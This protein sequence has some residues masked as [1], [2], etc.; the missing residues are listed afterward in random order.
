MSFE[1]KV[2]LITGAASG[3]GAETA[4]LLASLGGYLA[5]VD[6]NS[7]RLNHVAEE[8]I[9][10][11]HHIPFTIVADLTQDADHIIYE[12]IEKFGK[13]NVLINNVGVISAT[14][15]VDLDMG[16]YDLVM[17]TNVRSAVVLTKLAAPYLE[18]SKGNIVNVSSITGTRARPSRLAY[19]MSKAALNQFTKCIA[20][21]LGP[22]GIRVNA[23]NP[24]CVNTSL[25]ETPSERLN[26]LTNSYPLRRVGEATDVARSIAFL[27]SDDANF[28]TGNL[29]GVDGGAL[30]A[31]I[32]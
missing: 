32:V 7:D 23:V 16:N 22:R 9:G 29:F 28:I 3:I 17:N 5:M 25:T 19:S 18:D 15:L 24:G 10:A 26:Y 14:G 20:V 31:N 6:C 13:L 8:I 21:E 2:V 30:A 1:G 12:T 27:A 11:G 4:K